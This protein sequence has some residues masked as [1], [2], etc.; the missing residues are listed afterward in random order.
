[1]LP[2]EG[3]I[4]KLVP[5][6]RM[7]ASVTDLLRFSQEHTEGFEIQDKKYGVGQ[8][9]KIIHDIE[10]VKEY[11]DGHGGWIDFMKTILGKTVVV[12][13]VLPNADLLVLMPGS[14]WHLNPKCCENVSDSEGGR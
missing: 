4:E 2:E 7:N 10:K 14:M 6:L 1:M 12:K 11:Q 13:M 3:D 9:V 8:T 5:S